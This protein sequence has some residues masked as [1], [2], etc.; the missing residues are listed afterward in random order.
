MAHPWS[1]PPGLEPGLICGGRTGPFPVHPPFPTTSHFFPLLRTLV[2]A[3]TP[4]KEIPA[5]VAGPWD[6]V[7]R[8]GNRPRCRKALRARDSDAPRRFL[9]AQQKNRPR[10]AV[11]AT[12]GRVWI[13]SRRTCKPG[14]VSRA[15]EEGTGRRPFIWGGRYRPPLAAYPGAARATPSPPYLALLRVGFTVPRAV[16]GRAV[17]SYRTFSPLPVPDRARAGHRRSVL[18]GTFRGLTPPRCYLAPCPVEPGLSSA[19]QGRSD[20]RANSSNKGIYQRSGRPAREPPPDGPL[21]HCR[22]VAEEP[23]C[24]SYKTKAYFLFLVDFLIKRSKLLF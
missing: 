23:G 14:S 19:P 1:S 15:L 16:T 17:R 9:R 20:R 5:R 24:I 21:P 2:R 10:G 8:A 18:C 12:R 6:R 3:C 22:G 7:G 4:V 13:R 11:G